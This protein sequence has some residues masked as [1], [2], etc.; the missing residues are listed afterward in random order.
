MRDGSAKQT[1]II[2]NSSPTPSV[3]RNA[4]CVSVFALR[5]ITHW[6]AGRHAI[7]CWCVCQLA[8]DQDI[9]SSHQP[10]DRRARAAGSRALA[11]CVVTG[12][13]VCEAV[14]RPASWTRRASFGVQ[15]VSRRYAAIGSPVHG[16]QAELFSRQPHREAAACDV[17]ALSF[18]PKNAKGRGSR[19]GP[20]SYTQG[21]CRLGLVRRRQARP[22]NPT[23]GCPGSSGPGASA[24]PPTPRPLRGW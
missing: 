18:V 14:T 12:P 21:T 4:R 5:R 1:R 24:P 11:A 10:G 22:G 6:S 13:A 3:S 2:A 15:A 16:S 8:A 20:Y 17:R 23:A 19:R 9:G 7:A